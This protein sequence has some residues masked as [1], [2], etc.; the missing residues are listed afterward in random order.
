[1]SLTIGPFKFNFINLTTTLRVKLNKTKKIVLT[2]KQITTFSWMWHNDYEISQDKRQKRQTLKKKLRPLKLTKKLKINMAMVAVDCFIFLFQL[3]TDFL[4]NFLI[5][6]VH[7]KFDFVMRH[8][9]HME[10]QL[11]THCLF[12]LQFTTKKKKT[13]NQ[14]EKKLFCN[15]IKYQLLKIN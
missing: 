15:Y 11:I 5:D 7:F 9:I 1:M 14:T 8:F 12:L 13:K 2:K 3:T 6:S 10:F 4:C